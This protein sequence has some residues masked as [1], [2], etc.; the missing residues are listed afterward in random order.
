MLNVPSKLDDRG[1][2]IR[3]GVIGAGLFGT[4]LTDAVARVPG[5]DVVC[6]ADVEA[7][8][9]RGAFAEA[10][11]DGSVLE[12]DTPREPGRGVGVDRN[13]TGPIAFCPG[14]SHGET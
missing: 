9:A 13:G 10:G 8:R 4:K 11:T 7:D 2:D 6:V 14:Q 1:A 12:A 3:V 5:M